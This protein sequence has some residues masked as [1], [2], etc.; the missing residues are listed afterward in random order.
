MVISNAQTL[1]VWPFGPGWTWVGG[2]S[3]ERRSVP[4]GRGLTSRPCVLLGSVLPGGLV[5]PSPVT[6]LST[7]VLVAGLGSLLEWGGA[8]PP[9][10]GS[11]LSLPRRGSASS[12]VQVAPHPA[13][14]VQWRETGCREVKRKKSGP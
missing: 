11:G 2:M 14:P 5:S 1:L 9:A 13:G 10:G 8:P 3:A 4:A 6:A 7:S 12:A